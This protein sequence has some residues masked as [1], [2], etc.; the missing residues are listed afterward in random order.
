MTKKEETK[1]SEDTEIVKEKKKPAK[2]ASAKKAEKEVKEPASTD[3]SQGGEVT[4]E[5]KKKTKKEPKLKEVD[6][7]ELLK[8]G[9]H[10]GHQTHRWNPKMAPYIFTKKNNIHIIDLVKTGEKIKEALDFVYN[11]CA[12]GGSVLFVGTKK[13]AQKIIKEEADRCLS[14]YVSERWLGG[15][16][17]NFQTINTRIQYLDKLEE[18]IAEDSFTTK[19][20]KLDATNEREKLLTSFEGIRTMKKMPD[21]IFAVD[22]LKEGN[23]IKEAKNLSIPVVGIVDTNSNPDEINYVIPANDD[24]VRTIKIITEAIAD[25]VIEAR[26]TINKD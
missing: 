16:L 5:T 24:A 23:A 26:S 13:Q 6:L 11:I 8:A 22:V 20:E 18:R 17:T 7:Q 10:F 21:A 25:T 12:N 14:N 1:I 2:K 4:E 3:A 19:K 15:M 9:A